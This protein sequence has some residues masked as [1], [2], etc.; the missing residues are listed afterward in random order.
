MGRIGE[1]SQ[2]V[3]ATA[4]EVLTVEEEAPW[5]HEIQHLTLPELMER[6]RRNEGDR[7]LRGLSSAPR[8][9]ILELVHDSEE[10]H[11]PARRTVVAEAGQKGLVV[12]PLYVDS[13]G[14]QRIDV[15]FQKGNYIT[16]FAHQVKLS[17]PLP[18]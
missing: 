11:Q 1:I 16:V 4:K 7:A 6:L 8:R 17:D 13:D 9:H 5:E 10:R 14:D 18:S 2:Q 12:K 15:S 3:F